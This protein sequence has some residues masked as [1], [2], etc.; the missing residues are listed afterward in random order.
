MYN[1]FDDHRFLNHASF[2]LCWRRC[3]PKVGK[4]TH[5]KNKRMPMRCPNSKIVQ[6]KNYAE[7]QQSTNLEVDK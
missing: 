3:L 4:D 5:K 7:T 6:Q 2:Y 1:V